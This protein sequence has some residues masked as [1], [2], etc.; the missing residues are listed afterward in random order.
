MLK[1]ARRVLDY[2]LDENKKKVN[3]NETMCHCKLE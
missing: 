3:V 1:D 2:C